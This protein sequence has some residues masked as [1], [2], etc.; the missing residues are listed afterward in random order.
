MNHNPVVSHEEPTSKD[1]SQP[2]RQDRY[3]KAV[4]LNSRSASFISNEKGF[5]TF[6]IIL[7]FLG[8]VASAIAGVVMAN[9]YT[10][11]DFAGLVTGFI[12]F[13]TVVTSTLFIALGKLVEGVGV[14]KEHNE[15]KK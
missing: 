1:T 14:L 3:T 13:S 11:R 8:G 9:D 6:A 2:I 12:L 10:L 7:A 4:K 15:D 5:R